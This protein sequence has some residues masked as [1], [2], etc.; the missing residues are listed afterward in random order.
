MDNDTNAD[1]VFVL[2]D[3]ADAVESLRQEHGSV[4]VHCVKCESRTPSVAIAWL[5]RHG[6]MTFEAAKAVVSETMPNAHPN[7]SMLAALRS[8]Q[9]LGEPASEELAWIADFERPA[10]DVGPL[11]AINDFTSCDSVESSEDEIQLWLE[12]LSRPPEHNLDP[13]HEVIT[14]NQTPEGIQALRNFDLETIK[15]LREEVSVLQ[16]LLQVYEEYGTWKTIQVPPVINA[17]AILA[18]LPENWQR[19]LQGA[20]LA[21]AEAGTKMFPDPHQDE[22]L[23]NASMVAGS[24]Y[25]AHK[26]AARWIKNIDRC[27]LPEEL[28]QALLLFDGVAAWA[29]S[30]LD[31]LGADYPG[32]YLDDTDE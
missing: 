18:A 31:T 32:T 5:I 16:H 29:M 14:E 20:V 9:A 10:L 15:E 19:A 4:F 22:L 30:L 21:V 28:R 11:W 13:E 1:L 27:S 6:G 12:D 17:E 25:I 7:A 24:I 8:L 3:T 26:S 2:A 23:E